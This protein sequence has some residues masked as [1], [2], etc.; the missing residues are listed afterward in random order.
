MSRRTT[1]LVAH[2]AV[3]PVILTFAACQGDVLGPEGD[4]GGSSGLDFGAESV[5]NANGALTL[6]DLLALSTQ[7]QRLEAELQA[8]IVAASQGQG[9][10]FFRLPP[11]SALNAIPADPNNRLTSA[12]V[13]LGQLLFHETAL[14]VNNV[15]PEGL[16]TYSCAS[17]H[18]ADAAFMPNLPQGMAEGG[19][20]FGINGEGR[21]LNPLYDSNPDLPD[22]QPIRVPTNMNGAYQVV[23]LW[24][25]Q[26]GGVGPN[27]GTE[28][29]WVPPLIESNFLGL[30]GLET[31]AH[32]GLR[33]HR[34]ESIENSRVAT[35]S[36]YQSRFA[37]AFPGDPN[38]I[39]RLNAAL[40][41][42]A[43]ERTILTN[44]APWQRYLSGTR[45]ALSTD[46]KLGALVFFARANCTSCHTGP[47]LNTMS[48]HAL[49]MNDLDGSADPSRVNLVPFGG[50]VP[51][52][53]RRGR[54]GFTGNPAD[55]YMFKTP[56][57]YNLKAHAFL[58]HGS[59]FTSVRQVVEYKNA[60]IPQNAIVPAGQI[61]PLFQ[62]LGLDPV[63]INWLVDFVENGLY[64]PN[65]RRF[66]P[67]SILSGNCFPVND[68][69]A[70]SDLGCAPAALIA[71]AP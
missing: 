45:R 48:F 40:A 59:S 60:A 39:N 30:Q 34:M 10:A 53:A 28:A 57:L 26:F 38:P 2:F 15:R 70:R 63:E 31:Q 22:V 25:G 20:G 24:N 1:R 36:G 3:A 35:N 64:D 19:S 49:G 68:P 61:S 56:Q 8:A 4:R 37:R 27:L 55:D 6:A 65:M 21:V 44:Q 43:F 7:P 18:V 14:G 5:T 29:Q 54:G 50:T 69:Q 16:E 33:L 62:P 12:K 47:A 17:C 42:A 71:A 32:A 23:N 41:I 51:D 52:G 66:V 13:A 58:G 9:L 11:S 67:T 46:Q